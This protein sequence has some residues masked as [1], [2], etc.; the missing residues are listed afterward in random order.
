MRKI[1]ILTPDGV[2]STLL[3]RAACAWGNLTD[4][5]INPHEL[6]N[7]LVV[8]DGF[9][10][11]DWSLGYSQSLSEITSLISQEK[12]NLVVRLASYHIVARKDSETDRSYF[13]DF[14][15]S[16]FD[17][18]TCHRH[19]V[20]EYSMSWAIRDLKKTLNV[21]SYNQKEQIHP[22]TDTF[23]LDPEFITRTLN[24]YSDYERWINDNFSV[25]QKFYYEDI[26]SLDHF[27]DSM[28]GGS[29]DIFKNKFGLSLAEYCIFSNH[30]KDQLRF[31]DSKTVRSMISLRRYFNQLVELG[32]MPTTLPL[33]MNSFES[34]IRKTKNFNEILDT[35]NSWARNK[36]DHL[37]IDEVRLSELIKKD[38]FSNVR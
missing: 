10:Q 5:W 7:G 22:Q 19:N 17:I 20:F 23:E 31:L 14:L 21:Y 36:N 27:L 28:I 32:R 3:Q 24:N 12:E 18:I 4:V 11:K 15:N 13:Y 26:L 29:D 25:K 2:G 8:K 38:P 33:K 30:N 6:T 16:N 9:L 35:Y 34:K 1:L 37:E